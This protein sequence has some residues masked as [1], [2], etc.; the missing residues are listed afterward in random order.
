MVLS[1][2]SNMLSPSGVIFASFLGGSAPQPTTHSATLGRAFS[3]GDVFSGTIDIQYVLYM[4]LLHISMRS[5]TYILRVA[6]AVSLFVRRTR[7]AST[8]IV[9]NVQG[10]VPIVLTNAFVWY[11][12]QDSM[13]DFYVL[14]RFSAADRQH[15]TTAI[16]VVHH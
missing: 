8:G 6:A 14:P 4:L 11:L 16:I 9:T 7:P 1:C 5:F 13:T 12:N 2:V 15:S 10:P 3:L